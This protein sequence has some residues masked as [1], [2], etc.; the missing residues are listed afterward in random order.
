MDFMQL[1]SQAAQS[2]NLSRPVVPNRVL[3]ADADFFCY[4]C[5]KTDEHV[6]ENFRCLL[7]LIEVKRCMAGAQFVNVHVT[8]GMKGGREQMATV[9]PYQGKRDDHRDP[10]LK[11]R[12]HELRS[13]LANYKSDIVKPVVNLLQEADDSLCQQQLKRIK[14]HG[15]DSTVIMSGDKDLWM[16]DGLHCDGETGRMWRVKGYGLCEY[17]NVGNVKPKLMGEGTSWFWHQM[18][19]GD[20]ADNIPG[21]PM[22][23]G[24]LA[25]KYLPT[26]TL[27]RNRPAIACGEAKAVAMLLNVTTDQEAFNRVYEG[28]RDHYGATADEMFYEQAFLLWMRRTGDVHDVLNFLRPLGFK[29][30]LSSNQ[31]KLMQRFKELA[32]V[33]IRASKE[34]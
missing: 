23:S 32:L 9:K 11:A 28:Y 18:V 25:N 15:E 2:D 17:R 30:E 20:T 8:L 12:V 14:S 27:N 21:L 26:K 24:R 34:Q 10:A 5:A 19:M 1:G 7:D 3:Q 31:K 29:Y 16:V 4:Y 13:M 33:Q 6:N 22:L